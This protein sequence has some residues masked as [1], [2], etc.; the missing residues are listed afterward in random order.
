[1]I[2]GLTCSC[3]AWPV[4]G[5]RLIRVRPGLLLANPLARRPAWNASGAVVAGSAYADQRC[6]GAF[7]SDREYSSFA[8]LSGTNGHAEGHVR[9]LASYVLRACSRGLLAVLS[10]RAQAL[11]SQVAV[12]MTWP[13]A[14]ILLETG[15]LTV[16]G[17]WRAHRQDGRDGTSR[18]VS[19][20]MR[21]GC[22]RT[23]RTAS[24]GLNGS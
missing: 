23:L 5:S 20:A 9:Q 13:F 7:V 22:T 14:S 24:V 2:I 8:V 19:V 16:V 15:P 11:C 3:R 10:K 17:W 1:M 21:R 12:E 6:D 18:P 4:R